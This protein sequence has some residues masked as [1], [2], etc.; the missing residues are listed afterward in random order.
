MSDNTT[1]WGMTPDLVHSIAERYDLPDES[2]TL[3]A[4]I[5]EKNT[6]PEAQIRLPL[7]AMN[8]HGLIAGA[9]GTGKTRTL[10]LIAEGLASH[11][12]SVFLTDVKGD[13]TGLAQPGEASDKLLSRTETIGQDWKADAFTLEMLTLGSEGTEGTPVRATVSDFGPLLMAKVLD[14]NTT[15]EQALQLI[16]GWADQRGLGLIDLKDLKAVVQY[17]TNEGKAELKEIG[18]ISSATAGVILRSVSVLESQGGDVFFGTP[19]FDTKDFFRLDED[20]R[21][22]ISSLAIPQLDTRPAL[23]STFIMWLLADLF[24]TLPEVGDQPKPKLVFFFD[25][26]HLLFKSA[27]PTFLDQVVQ[28]VKLIRSKGVGVFFIT[29][30]PQDIPEAVLSQLGSRVMHAL[31]AYTPKDV[32]KL[33]DTVSTFPKTQLDLEE[34]ITTLGTGEALVTVLGDKG[35]PTPVAPTRLCAPAAD[36]GVADADIIDRVVTD[37]VIRAKYLESTDPYSAFEALSEVPN[38]E[39]A[40]PARAEQTTVSDGPDIRPKYDDE[41][42]EDAIRGTEKT[43]SKSQRAANDDSLGDVVTGMLSNA[44]RSFGTQLGREISRTIF[45]TRRRRR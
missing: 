12:V 9:T 20:G 34:V 41:E 17:L 16:F 35:V 8:R 42:L 38:D 13:L 18:G 2:I 30:T 5:D 10:Q 37:S 19:A 22:I 27:S 44:M 23:V 24:D 43:R 36:M 45:G 11:G 4:L 28:T 31:R 26:A 15:Q 21:G 32:D 14:L 1:A 39:P 33:K 29:Q 6:Y 40:P 7:K 25:E 3:G